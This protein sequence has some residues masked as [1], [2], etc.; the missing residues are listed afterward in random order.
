MQNREY[1]AVSEEDTVYWYK[2]IN[3][4]CTKEA[5]IGDK[6]SWR[7]TMQRDKWRGHRKSWINFIISWVLD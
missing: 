6:Q 2:Y 3:W 7:L 1:K 5:Y 4:H